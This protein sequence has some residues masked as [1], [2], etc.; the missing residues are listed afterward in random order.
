MLI[1][2]N[3]KINIGL[4]ILSKREDG[5]HNIETLFLPVKGLTDALEF[6]PAERTVFTV[7]G[8]SIEGTPPENMVLKAYNLLQQRFKL[9]PLAI[10]LHKFIPSGAGLG[11][12]S[13]DA[14]F[15]LYGLKDF[16]NLQIQRKEM[17]ELCSQIGSD[18][19][20]F[21]LNEPAFGS[22]K[23][24]ILQPVTLKLHGKHFMIIKPPFS[25]STKDA[26]GA[27]QVSRPAQNLQNL[28]HQPIGEWKY[29]IG[30]DFEPYA[31][32]QFPELEKIK[33]SMYAMG[34]VYASM[35]GSGSA[36]FGIFEE[37]PVR[38]TLPIDYFCWTT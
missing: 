4:N 7:S 6:I 38:P 34:A 21:I 31:F 1:F 19:A 9:P 26:Y 37:L 8:L 23:G 10:H 13:S 27:I 2:P 33:S 11:G 16:F 35:S 3:A 17:I 22:G 29:A 12:G 15:M 30:N 32:K 5:Y 24:E 18:C 20:F 25:I 14:S 28:I 36:I